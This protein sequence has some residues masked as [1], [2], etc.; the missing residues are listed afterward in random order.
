RE[1]TTRERYKETQQ[2]LAQQRRCCHVVYICVRIFKVHNL[3]TSDP[4]HLM[5]LSHIDGAKNVLH[6]VFVLANQIIAKNV[7]QLH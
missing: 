3:H 7:V 5:V 6:A 1:R 4:L 2:G